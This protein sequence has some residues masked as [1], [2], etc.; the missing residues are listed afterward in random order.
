MVYGTAFCP[1]NEAV[2]LTKLECDDSKALTEKVRE[3]I[4][5]KI[6]KNSNKIGW[7]VEVISPNTISNNM[8][9]RKK[10]SLNEISMNSAI[11]LIRAALKNEVNVSHVY[12]DTVGPPEKYQ[13]YLR[14]IFPKLNI[15]VSKKADSLYPVVS[16]ASICAKVTRDHALQTWKFV[17][18]LDVTHEQ[19]GS[20]YPADPLTKKFL[21]Q[22]CD[23]VFGFPQ[24][25]RSSWSTASKILD[26]EA[27][28]VE[29]DN[30]DD[31]D[32]NAK[33][34]IKSKSITSFFKIESLDDKNTAKNP[35]KMQHEFFSSRF[36]EHTTEL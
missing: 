35:Q 6:C 26:E 8:L 7:A 11:G 10:T 32:S 33:P 9:S 2:L 30:D 15:T 34:E 36:L 21:T 28:Y 5:G 17:E 1:L 25:V 24:L 27:Y 22:N 31:G 13:N 18:G 12:V 23:M 4:F 19:F 14:S 16:A 20:G 29:W 3:T